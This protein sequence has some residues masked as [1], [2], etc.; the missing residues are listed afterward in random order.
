MW[1]RHYYIV[2]TQI[3]CV[4]IKF[5]ARIF[6]YQIVGQSVSLTLRLTTDKHQQGTLCV[7]VS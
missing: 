1:Y 2:L 3:F 6:V 7:L 5:S 4:F